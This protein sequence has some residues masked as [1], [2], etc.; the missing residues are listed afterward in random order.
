MQTREIFY[1]E[2]GRKERVFRAKTLLNCGIYWI[3]N[4]VNNKI[5]IG[6]SIN[7]KKRFNQHKSNLRHNRHCN[8]HLQRA[9][10][11]YGEEN[12]IFQLVEHHAYPERILSRENKYISL[13]KPEYNNIL[14]NDENRPSASDETRRK[15]STSR[16]GRIP[17]NKG[18]KLPPLSDDR[19]RQLSELFK[20]RK[21]KP[22]SDEQKATISN[23]LKGRKINQE[24][25]EKLLLYRKEKSGANHVMAKKVYQY[26]LDGNFIKEWNY[27]RET[28]ELGVDPVQVSACATGVHKTA[29]GY[30]WYF[31]FRGDKIEPMIL[32]R[33]QKNAMKK[34][35]LTL[36]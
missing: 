21:G 6:S 11:K 15:M 33:Y 19:K 22:V 29:F 28:K 26:N 23:S 30:R 12:F 36:S 9:W 34:Y 10:N 2:E 4:L 17:W 3:T 35:L 8:Q 14:V 16:M 5:Y 24:Q 7:I 20:G 31:D 13:Y 25:Y 18:L 1:S 27:I 32:S